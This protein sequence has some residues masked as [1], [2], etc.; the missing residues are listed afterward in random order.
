MRPLQSYS[1]VKIVTAESE[2]FSLHL[3]ELIARPE[4][5]GQDFRA[6]SLAA[7]LF[8]AE[9][10]VRASRER[11]ADPRAR[12][13]RSTAGSI[14]CSP[15]IRPPAPR[16]DR[17]DVLAFWQRPQLHLAVQLHRR[18]G[19]RRCCAASR[20]MACRCRC[21]SPAGR[22]TMPACCAPATPSSRRPASGG[23][24]R[25]SMPAPRRR[26]STPSPGCPTRPRSRRRSAATLRAAARRAGL[27][28]PEAIMEELVAVAPLALAMA[29]RL[30]R[31]HG[32]E[33][34]VSSIFDPGR[35]VD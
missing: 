24:G 34:E 4:A 7:C 21:R 14:C 12:C 16:L 33:Q 29:R 26:R 8:T 23:G 13:A 19:A 32:R 5:F 6:R 3:P 20:A 11:R 30:G 17:H 15:P 31:D 28:L 10:Y 1:D 22:S 2:L 25:V 9:D 18:P 27:R 35:D